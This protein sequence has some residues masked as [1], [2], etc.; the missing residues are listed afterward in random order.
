M[1]RKKKVQLD[2]PAT[3]AVE[4]PISPALAREQF[5][6]V[7][8]SVLRDWKSIGS[9]NWGTADPSKQLALAKR[10][11]ASS[12]LWKRLCRMSIGCYYLV[13]KDGEFD[14]ELPDSYV[15]DSRVPGSPLIDP[16]FA[17]TQAPAIWYA[18]KQAD[19][20]VV[21]L[22]SRQPDTLL[23]YL[24]HSPRLLLQHVR[25]FWRARQ[26]EA[27]QVEDGGDATTNELHSNLLGLL[28]SLDQSIRDA[29]LQLAAANGSNAPFFDLRGAVF[30]PPPKPGEDRIPF[31]LT[32]KFLQSTSE[33]P[34]L[35]RATAPGA[36]QQT[37]ELALRHLACAAFLAGRLDHEAM[38]A[39]MAA[40]TAKGIA[41]DPANKAVRKKAGDTK[42]TRRL[43]RAQAMAHKLDQV[44]A[45]KRRRSEPADDYHG[46]VATALKERYGGK[47]DRDTVG[48]YLKAKRPVQGAP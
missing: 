26:C 43:Q 17:D 2:A 12:P 35:S 37:W 7:W 3:T 8:R 13:E 34:A 6:R 46:R 42:R 11:P 31:R 39:A 25:T 23:P 45:T 24:F 14:F 28:S 30:S 10:Y 36:Q 5:I 41:M 1:P 40:A 18:P 15:F 47:W 27:L 38:V 19:V 48:S 44:D 32:I 4:W 21:N 22:A 29:A 20:A 33:Q 16:K 9:P